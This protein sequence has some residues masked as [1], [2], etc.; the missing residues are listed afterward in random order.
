MAEEE[1]HPRFV[2]AI[3]Q[4]TTATRAHQLFLDGTFQP[5]FSVEHRQH[6]PQ[7]GW[8]EHDTRELLANIRQCLDYAQ[9]A[10]ALAIAN[11]GQTAIA[12]DAETGEPLGNAI[13]W[14][15][16]R[17]QS[18]I[19]RLRADGA[20]SVTLERAGLP[21]DAH[22]AA[23]KL[24]WIL[25]HVPAAHSLASKGRLRLSTSDAYFLDRLCGDY[26]TDVTTASHTGLMN[27]ATTQWDPEL[28]RLFGVPM[29]LLPPIRPTAFEHGVITGTRLPLVA[30]MANQQAALFGHGC[31]ARGQMKI[32]FGADARALAVAGNAPVAAPDA[33]ILPTVAWRLGS[34]T[35]YAIDGGVF[36]AVSALDWA[37]R[38]G[39]FASIRELRDPTGPSA[40]ER[41]LAFVPALSGLAC[42]YRDRSAAGLW[43]GMDL[44]TTRL[45]LAQ[46]VLEGVALRSAQALSAMHERVPLASTVSIDGG[47]A[48][49]PYFCS[50]L[51]RALDRKVVVPSAPDLTGLGCA[52]FAFI[53]AGFGPLETLPPVA[54]PDRIVQP[55]VPL[56]PEMHARFADAV[57]RARRWRAC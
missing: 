53:G 49:N 4:G 1:E 34:R 28:C 30:S 35:T 31:H 54:S 51:A 16:Q 10:D 14:Q 5:M 17:T 18:T 47:L 15:D 11:Q 25:D 19:D 41:G 39:L 3:D 40:L 20:E 26:A 23:T 52:Q 56:H 42:P 21:L 13:A 57:E 7:A 55:D 44:D 2:V 9:G 27:L 32:T 22:F 24:R 29:D 6:H 12:W 36:N 38:L 45:D 50:F 37:R 46:A 33:G 8:I 43:L 48:L